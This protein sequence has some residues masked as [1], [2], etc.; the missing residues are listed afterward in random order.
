MSFKKT[1]ETQ[2]LGTFV[3]QPSSPPSG[4]STAPSTTP[5]STTPAEVQAGGK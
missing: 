4:Q 1:G 2:Q 3:L 5:P